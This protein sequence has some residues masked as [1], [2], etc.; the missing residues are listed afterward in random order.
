MDLI[1]ADLL[2][3]EPFDRRAERSQQCALHVQLPRSGEEL[4]GDDRRG[5]PVRGTVLGQHPADDALALAVAVDLGRVEERDSGV[6]TGV[7][8]FTDGLLAQVRVIAAHAPR[9]LVA[10][11]PRAD[12]ERRDRDGR[13][14]QRDRCRRHG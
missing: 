4:G 13:A 7:P 2:D 10:P 6:E 8:G 9:G 12:A 3:A 5:S 14:S 11:R 1:E